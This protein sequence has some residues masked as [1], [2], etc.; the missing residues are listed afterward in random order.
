MALEAAYRE[1][2]MPHKILIICGTRPEAIKLAPVY[3]E[4]AQ[5]EQ[6]RVRPAVTAQHREMLDQVLDCFDITPD[7]DLNVMAHGQSL[8]DVTCRSLRGLEPVLEEE[9]PDMVLVQGDTA[10]VLAGALAAY[11]AR[12]AVG[13]VEA[14]LR[15]DDIY[16]P[17]PEEMLR[18]LTTQIATL[19]FAPTPN[20]RENLLQDGVAGGRVF[21]TGNTVV[22]ALQAVAARPAPP[23]PADLQWLQG[24]NGRLVLATVHRRENLGERM[25]RIF[26]A[27]RHI[28]DRFDDVAVVYAAHK[29]PRVREIAQRHLAGAARAYIVEP[30]EYATFIHVVKRADLIV[31]DS[32]GL[33]EEA[34]SLDTPLLVVRET[35][36]RPEGIEA[37]AVQ[38]V[39]TRTESIVSSATTLLT[40]QQAYDEMARAENP[41]GDGRAAQRIAE[42]LAFHF[43]A[44][45]QPPEAFDPAEGAAL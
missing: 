1:P 33:Q 18:R 3:R 5:R 12:V 43:G 7:H 42:A 13:H 32:G 9:R 29:N 23:W 15:T 14:G 11:Y 24:F 38:L 40:D 25:D 17:F 30:P 31:T 6:F 2:V 37:G 36:E 44:R 28:V 10:T 39:G 19:H 27:L 34:P 45:S 20:A 41:Y 4:L 21:V 8:S 35:T 22:D 26:A 16:D